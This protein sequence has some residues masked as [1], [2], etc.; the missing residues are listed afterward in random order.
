LTDRTYVESSDRFLYAWP[1]AR[2]F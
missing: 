2:G 1:R